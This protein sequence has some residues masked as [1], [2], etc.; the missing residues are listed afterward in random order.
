MLTFNLVIGLGTHHFGAV[1]LEAD[2]NR[3]L[4]APCMLPYLKLE[5]GKAEMFT[6]ERQGLAGSWKAH[7]V[8][9]SYSYSTYNIIYKI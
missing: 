5:R 1:F 4:S 7:V 2:F 3:A 8:Y 6:G 9:I